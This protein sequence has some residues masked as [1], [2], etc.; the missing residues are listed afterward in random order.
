MKNCFTKVASVLFMV[1]LTG[2]GA[3]T[4][5]TN[6]SSA[7][8]AISANLV[9]GS[10][11]AAQSGARALA[12][13]PSSVANIQLTVSGTGSNGPIPVVKS[14]VPVS[15]SA[16]IGGI[17]P[18]T[19]ALAVKAVDTNNTVLY[20]GFALNAVITEGGTTNVGTI[21]MTPP[22]VKDEEKTCLGCHEVALDNTGQSVV[23]N[24]KQSGHYRNTAFKD[25]NGQG[26]GCVG[27]HGPQHNIPNPYA[28]R[29]FECHADKVPVHFNN[30]TGETRP[31]MYVST[32]EKCDSCHQAHN[33]KVGQDE[34]KAYAKS[35][36]GIVTGAAWS[37]EDFGAACQR[38]HS[39]TGFKNFAVSNFKTFPTT[40]IYMGEDKKRE[41]LGCDG[42]HTDN[43]FGV[44]APGAFTSQ[45][46]I[47]GNTVT[48]TFP[49]AGESNLCIACHSARENGVD[50][51]ADFTNA[52]FK[53]SHY[54]PA[55]ATM[56][57]SAGFTNFTS[58]SAA[59]GA[60]TYGQSLSPDN[61][62]VPNF[63][64]A[65]GQGSTHRKLGTAGIVGDHGITAG[66]LDANGP[67]VVCHMNAPTPAGTA[68]SAHG[69]TLEIDENAYN[70][71]C[72]NC[73][74]SEN[75]VAI[76]AGNFKQYFLEPQKEAYEAAIKLA[77]TLLKQKYNI[78][79]DSASYPYFF[80]NGVAVKNW[81]NGTGNQALGKKI[82]G[83]CFNIQLLTKDEAGYAHARSY[84]RRLAY[85]TIDFLDDGVINL[86]VANTAVNSGLTNGDGA[87]LYTMG[88]KAYNISGGKPSTIY[89][90]TSEASLY[91][92]GWSRS[93]GDW[94]SPQ[95]P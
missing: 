49:D 50:A 40:S 51:V 70:Q 78:D 23:A 89:S 86:S 30:Y 84:T 6:S 29:C 11:A 52:S 31:A 8:G 43:N 14:T 18:G 53:N 93:T 20:E 38:C 87:P 63:G 10:K 46:K 57:M 65:G 59:I 24:Y 13:A 28:G 80:Q 47:K 12:A 33:T 25:A 1:A 81:T 35:A 61:V 37:A 66:N 27:C 76:N 5:G 3:N 68:R 32:N 45:Y 16:Q 72:I 83:A 39:G 64:V 69:H 77:V 79:Y 71:V 2:C 19:V 62:T 58:A 21:Y 67:C 48:A 9:W 95:R 75:T 17:Y 54:L 4:A 82:M 34:R 15:G 92:M 41:V 73:H 90:G 88:T 36:H 44:R 91:L 94:T 60:S 26:A 42:C 85:D 7:P 74:T 56:Y 22:V 55:A